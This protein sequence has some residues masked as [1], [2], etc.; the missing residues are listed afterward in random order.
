MITSGGEW[1][2]CMLG[3]VARVTDADAREG[4]QNENMNVRQTCLRRNI[5][6]LASCR[7]FRHRRMRSHRVPKLDDD[8]CY[9]A[10]TRRAPC[11]S[12]E[13]EVGNEEVEERGCQRGS[14]REGICVA[15]FG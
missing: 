8:A 10:L 14:G 5:P 1:T 9:V 6:R 12:I 4:M 15:P 7:R 2:A 11:W 13:K 3:S